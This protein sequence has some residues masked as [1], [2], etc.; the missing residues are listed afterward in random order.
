[1]ESIQT[2][3]VVVVI[4]LTTLLIVIGWQVLMMILD[5]R[6]GLKKLN[7]LLDDSIIG[8]GLLRQ[9]KLASIFEFLKRKTARRN[10]NDESRNY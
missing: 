9:D 2:L 1:M 5:L 3:L 4:L 7:S 6:R 10:T 8:G